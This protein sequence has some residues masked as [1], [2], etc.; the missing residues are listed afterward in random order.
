MVFPPLFLCFLRVLSHLGLGKKGG[1]WVQDRGYEAIVDS[2]GKVFGMLLM[3]AGE[4]REFQPGVS[5]Q[6]NGV[7]FMMEAVPWERSWPDP[8]YWS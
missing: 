4:G 6:R 3:L 1:S 8:G 7:E 2:Y 5:S